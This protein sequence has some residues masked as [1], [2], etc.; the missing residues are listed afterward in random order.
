[1][2]AQLRKIIVRLGDL[3]L[4]EIQYY[5]ND[6]PGPFQAQYLAYQI[7]KQALKKEMLKYQSS[8]ICAEL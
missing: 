3:K 4:F 5:S 6:Y 1:L 7:A 8:V 2:K